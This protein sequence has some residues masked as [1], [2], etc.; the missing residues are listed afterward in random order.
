MCIIGWKYGWNY[1]VNE[2]V[3]TGLILLSDQIGLNEGNYCDTVV[4]SSVH[5]EAS[6][7]NEEMIGKHKIG[8]Y[9]KMPLAPLIFQTFNGP[10]ELDFFWWVKDEKCAKY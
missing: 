8:Q 5:V 4:S 10:K 3:T 2:Q 7:N 6:P 1:H 9:L